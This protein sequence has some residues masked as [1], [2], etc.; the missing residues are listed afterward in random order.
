M[1]LTKEQ[2]AFFDETGYLFLPECF[3]LTEVDTI[4][5]EL[6]S[7]F[8]ER[9]QR[10]VTEKSGAFVRSVY[11]SHMFNETFRLLARHPRLVLPAMQL[12]GSEVYVYQF[13]VN[14]KASFG[15]DV[16]EWHQDYVF[17]MKEDGLPA[18]DI[19]N[20]VLFLNEV[21]E[22]NGPLYLVPGSHREGVL[23]VPA[24]DPADD[25]DASNPYRESPAWISNLTADLKYSLDRETVERLVCKY[26]IVAP[27]GRGG[28]VLFFHSNL[29]H[30]SPNNISPFDRVVVLVTFNSIRN[31]PAPSANP[32]PN[33]LAS[34]D[35]EPV[36]PVADGALLR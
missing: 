23:D 6:P 16:W 35:Y 33:F 36:V 2:A 28:S 17:W 7:T 24:K 32:R 1:Q 25:A 5:A 19:V 3:S 29:V 9:S 8:A 22:F 21:N 10:R 27:K 4:R 31:I 11:G 26:G 12:L 14:A 30:G 13:K 15:G 34:R 20:A 18:P